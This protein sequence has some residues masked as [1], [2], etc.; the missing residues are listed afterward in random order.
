MMRWK[1][2][3][4]S[5]DYPKEKC[6]YVECEGNEDAIKESVR[7]Y[8]GIP[9][10]IEIKTRKNKNKIHTTMKSIYQKK[11]LAERLKEKSI[12][13]WEEMTDYERIVVD[14][15]RT[16]AEHALWNAFDNDEYNSDEYKSY[17]EVFWG[18]ESVKDWEFLFDI[19]HYTITVIFDVSGQVSDDEQS[20]EIEEY[21][22][23]EIQVVD[24]DIDSRLEYEKYELDPED[25]GIDVRQV[26]EYLNL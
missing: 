17:S 13:S 14:E 26:Q 15:I 12:R 25:I 21:T 8:F 19:D 20:I 10:N 6:V 4:K 9:S 1:V 7:A 2:S 5:D 23:S 11:S 18:S 22:I 24:N 16:E 3:W